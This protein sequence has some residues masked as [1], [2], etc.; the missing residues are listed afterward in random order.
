MFPNSC[1]LFDRR[2]SSP[3]RCLLLACFPPPQSPGVYIC[4]VSGRG[5]GIYCEACRGGPAEGK[6]EEVGGPG[7]VDRDDEYMRICE[8]VIL[9]HLDL[10]QNLMGLNERKV[11]CS[12]GK[13][14]AFHERVRPVASY[15]FMCTCIGVKLLEGQRPVRAAPSLCVVSPRVIALVDVFPA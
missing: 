3:Y 15:S 13:H 7:V 12:S 5:K 9:R 6:G 11:R 10:Q 14:G 2:I 8:I 1:C 4:P